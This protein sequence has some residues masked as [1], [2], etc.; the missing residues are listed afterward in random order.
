MILKSTAA[1]EYIGV[2]INTIKT[3]ANN[4]KIIPYGKVFKLRIYGLEKLK[5]FFNYI[6]SSDSVLF[7]DRKKKKFLDYFDAV[8]GARGGRKKKIAIVESNEIK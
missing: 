4:G 1:A 6:Y 3:L 2:S 8:Y 7:L 5:L